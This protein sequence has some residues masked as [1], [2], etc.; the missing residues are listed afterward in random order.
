M[1]HKKQSIIIVLLFVFC[2]S[3]AAEK[4]AAPQ[5][6]PQ[7][8]KS[9]SLISNNQAT[10]QTAYTLPS[11]IRFQPKTP[12]SRT[13]SLHPYKR[14]LPTSQQPASPPQ[15]RPLTPA[16]SNLNNIPDFMLPEQTLAIQED[17]RPSKVARTASIQNNELRI[18]ATLG[19]LALEDRKS[20]EKRKKANKD[21]ANI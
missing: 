14:T 19:H 3:Q 4:K 1:N 10:A 15:T 2:H 6:T 13:V 5:L 11:L 9:I 7:A 20:E 8:P 21:N 12:P 16:P 17:A 18:F